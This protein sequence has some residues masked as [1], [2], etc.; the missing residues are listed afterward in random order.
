MFHKLFATALPTVEQR[1]ILDDI[2]SKFTDLPG[3]VKLYVFGSA[4]RLEMTTASDVDL[5]AVFASLE[6]MTQAKKIFYKNLISSAWSIDLIWNFSEEFEYSCK[7]GG[8]AYVVVHEGVLLF[9]E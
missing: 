8:I 4:A 2:K 7:R 1:L 9:A 5:Y 6:L 3:L